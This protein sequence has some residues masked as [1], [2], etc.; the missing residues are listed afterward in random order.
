MRLKI[1]SDIHNEIRRA[2]NKPEFLIPEH[3]NDK[4]TVLILAGDI[5]HIKKT[6]QYA[7]KYSDK[8]KAVIFVAGNHE[9]YGQHVQKDEH[10]GYSEKENVHFLN[11]STVIIDGVRFIGGT[12]WTNIDTSPND[13]N[14]IRNTI[15]DYKY[16][17]YGTNYSRLKIND[18]LFE[19]HK[20]KDFFKKE[21]KKEFDGKTVVISHHPPTLENI[22]YRENDP[23]DYT[24]FSTDLEEIIN[25][26][27]IWING[28][29]HR[30]LDETRNGTRYIVN[31][32]GYINQ[33]VSYKDEY[34]FL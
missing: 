4:E 3:E 25:K 34:F 23:A 9:Y 26:P 32:V 10:H 21:L 22:S 29:D 6:K 11:N 28:H 13:Y 19:H 17:R 15:S 30:F 24:Y 12:L 27:D 14:F 33:N 7:E 2:K 8:F 31:A 20:T 18:V 16:I 1:F 5:D